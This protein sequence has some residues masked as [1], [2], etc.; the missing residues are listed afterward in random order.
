MVFALILAVTSAENTKQV[1][2]SYAILWYM[3]VQSLGSLV[4]FL[5]VFVRACSKT[6]VAI[7]IQTTE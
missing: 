2:N 5:A 1:C 6:T 3:S 7:Q 4:N